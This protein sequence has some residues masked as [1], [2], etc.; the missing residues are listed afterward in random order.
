MNPLTVGLFVDALLLLNSLI[1]ATANMYM[2]FVASL[3]RCEISSSE[4]GF[5]L[6]TRLSALRMYVCIVSPVRSA[7]RSYKVLVLRMYFD[8]Y[9]RT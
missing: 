9:M 2:H 3:L 1:I 7:F 6:T 8:C 4:Y 5:S